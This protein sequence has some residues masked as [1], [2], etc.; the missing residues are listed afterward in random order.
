MTLPS[1]EFTFKYPLDDGEDFISVAQASSKNTAETLRVQSSM[2]I[3]AFIPKP[4]WVPRNRKYSQN[5][6]QHLQTEMLDFYNYM[7]PT[8]AEKELRK[9]AVE[10]VTRITQQVFPESQIMIFG[11]FSTGL[12]LPTSDLDLVVIQKRISSSASNSSKLSKA[13]KRIA[14]HVEVISNAKVPLIKIVDSL[15]HYPIDISF[16]LNNGVKTAEIVQEVLKDKCIGPAVGPLILTLKL[17]LIQ[18]HQNEVFTGGLGSYG[19]LIMV[20]GFLKSHPKLATGQI[21]AIDNLGI[22]FIEFLELYGRNINAEKVGVS[23]S[24]EEFF[25]EKIVSREQMQ[26]LVART[27]CA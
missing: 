27:D 16:N 26:D 7:S 15:T 5:L 4:V 9:L 20:C 19:L 13:I 3:Y 24:N 11:S 1:S 23:V 14:S 2:D 25:S 17:F 10:R 22:L 6:T 21:E 18:R 8:E 12:Y